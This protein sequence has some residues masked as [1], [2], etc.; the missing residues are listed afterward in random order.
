[1]FFLFQESFHIAKRWHAE[2][3]AKGPENI[4]CAMIGCKSDL[5]PQREVLKEDLHAFAV[6][7]GLFLWFL[8]YL[9]IFL[10]YFKEILVSEEISC[11][12]G[13]NVEKIFE[14]ICRYL[15]QPKPQVK[16]NLKTIN[17]R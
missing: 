9:E 6:E 14:N 10:N 5:T 15:I 16:K 8:L 13:K 1:M 12:T 11:K 3:I 17:N 2:I 7:N 4:R